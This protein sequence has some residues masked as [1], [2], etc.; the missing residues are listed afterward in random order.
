MDHLPTTTSPE[1]S[2]RFPVKTLL[3]AGFILAAAA[4]ILVFRVPW[5]TVLYYGFSV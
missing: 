2:R 4:A 5:T 3:V 1:E